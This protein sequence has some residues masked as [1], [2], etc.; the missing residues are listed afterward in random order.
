MLSRFEISLRHATR[1]GTFA[2]EIIIFIAYRLIILY[3]TTVYHNC[4]LV[5]SHPPRTPKYAN[6]VLYQRPSNALVSLALYIITITNAVAK[7]IDTARD[8][9]PLRTAA[10]PAHPSGELH[11]G[12]YHSRP[13]GF[14]YE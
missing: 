6:M 14:P 11:V 12:G 4:Y 8:P 5:P 10:P 2:L 3:F 9:I 1:T 13:E 7:A